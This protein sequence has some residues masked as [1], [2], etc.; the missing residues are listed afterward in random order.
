MESVAMAMADP[1]IFHGCLLL[2][3]MHW[4][5]INGD[6]T[7]IRETYLHHK[8][9]V[10]RLVNEQLAVAGASSSDSVIGAIACL[11]L[12]EVSCMHAHSAPPT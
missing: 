2:A 4:Y 6:V 1:S 11:A 12:A 9:E 3:G 7:L 5:W 10:I 8:L